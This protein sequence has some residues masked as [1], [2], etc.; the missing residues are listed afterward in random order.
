MTTR[1]S[2]QNQPGRQKGNTSE[3]VK[4]ALN[5]LKSLSEEERVLVKAQLGWDIPVVN[6]ERV[7][8]VRPVRAKRKYNRDEVAST[9]EIGQST[10]LS[11]LLSPSSWNVWNWSTTNESGRN[12]LQSLN[13]SH[14]VS[15]KSLVSME[16][17]EACNVPSAITHSMQENVKNDTTDSVIEKHLSKVVFSETKHDA[18]S[19]RKEFNLKKTRLNPCIILR[20][21]L[22]RSVSMP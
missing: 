10:F 19:S 6:P 15:E 14:D 4:L 18:G 12:N 3:P 20:S 22:K 11:A 2:K 17:D 13:F 8:S 1:F 5:A 21:T 9:P 7:N 16:I